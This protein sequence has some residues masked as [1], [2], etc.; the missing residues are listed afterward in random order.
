MWKAYLRRFIKATPSTRGTFIVARRHLAVHKP[1]PKPAHTPMEGVI[2]YFTVE[3]TA[4]G[5]ESIIV[6]SNDDGREVMNEAVV[7]KTAM[8][9]L[10]ESVSPDNTK[11][12][13]SWIV[14][15]GKESEALVM[16][17]GDRVY[18]LVGE[19][20]AKRIADEMKRG[21]GPWQ[22]EG[23]AASVTKQGRAEISNIPVQAWHRLAYL[24]TPESTTSELGENWTNPMRGRIYC[25]IEAHE[26][27]AKK[28]KEL[29]RGTVLYDVLIH[30]MSID[31]E[32]KEAFTSG[33]PGWK[34]EKCLDKA[35]VKIFGIESKRILKFVGN[36]KVDV[37]N[38]VRRLHTLTNTLTG[39]GFHPEGA[40]KKR[41]KTWQVMAWIYV[42]GVNILAV[43]TAA[44]NF[45]SRENLFERLTDMVAVQTTLLVSVFGLVKLTSEDPNAIRN[46]LRGF[47]V[48]RHFEEVVKETKSN[49]DTEI[50]T[51]LTLGGAR[52]DWLDRNGSCYTAFAGGGLIRDTEGMSVSEL[53]RAGWKFSNHSAL[54]IITNRFVTF[55]LANGVGHMD[56]LP[57]SGDLWLTHCADDTRVMGVVVDAN[58]VTK[59]A[60]KAS[61]CS[62]Q[63]EVGKVE[64]GLVESML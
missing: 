50:K 36:V 8:K 47:K 12:K 39:I 26:L 20:Q 27:V 43:L 64:L 57:P 3:V 2:N 48:L 56:D 38:D 42:L 63:I 22:I 18:L 16:E 30:A 45:A 6:L 62:M 35:C 59:K 31:I 28:V 5:G 34:V 49:K 55:E 4:N 17:T 54:N 44:L 51:I 24:E 29:R 41:G 21:P 32:T 10:F 60:E 15:S 37:W 23:V 19:Q 7:K 58:E 61:F 53:K 13:A 52:S 14:I 11:H 1:K 25:A 9:G 46:T 33:G 40:K